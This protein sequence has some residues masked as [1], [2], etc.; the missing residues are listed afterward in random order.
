MSLFRHTLP[1][2][3]QARQQLY[4][5]ITIAALLLL[6]FGGMFLLTRLGPRD[7][8][9]PAA[10]STDRMSGGTR[11]V[12]DATLRQLREDVALLLTAFRQIPGDQTVSAEELRGI[13]EAIELQRRILAGR[14][15]EIA[16]QADVDRLEELLRI[17]DEHMGAFLGAQVRDA[18]AAAE[19][20][21]NIRDHAAAITHLERALHLQREIN[22]RYRR[23]SARNVSRLAILE[24]R[25]QDWRAQPVHD[26]SLQHRARAMAALDRRDFAEARTE[27][28]A[29]LALQRKLYEEHR[30]ARV[31]SLSRLRAF[32]K[33]W[34]D[35]EA[36][37]EAARI[38]DLEQQVLRALDE[39]DAA[40]AID[41][42]EVAIRL[43]Q[44]LAARFPRSEAARP[45]RAEDLLTLRETAASLPGQQRV[46]SLLAE[47]DRLLP[48]AAQEPIALTVAELFR[49]L[50]QLN[51][52]YPRS[53]LLDAGQFA[54]IQALHAIR[55][56][57]AALRDTVY[58]RLVEIPGMPGTR[59]L[60]SEVWQALY[61]G[62]ARANPSSQPGDT[63][64]VESVTW[65][66]AQAFCTMLGWMLARPVSLPNR[67]AYQAALGEVHTW[68]V[69]D[70]SW[71]SQNTDRTLRPVR[72]RP[73]NSNGFIDLL[74][75]VA[76]W[77]DDAVANDTGKAV[78]IGGSVR[79]N[80]FRL[81]AVPEE[82][83]DRGERNRFVG[84]RFMLT[85]RSP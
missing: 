18:E 70:L 10:T 2:S 23:A 14:P 63:L 52:S 33:D 69:V 82:V 45:A 65:D 57:I 44:E 84:F 53:R 16:P 61:A 21:L 80:P 38:S 37:E 34:N 36:A 3:Q 41:R 75:N 73:P 46:N 51:R 30:Q 31:A 49:Q 79:D 66:E 6:L 35:M 47:L 55:E 76:E 68:E 81:A 19:E 60:D 74:G 12:D 7:A 48:A 42:I 29:A 62:I 39:G 4:I 20:A 43:Q 54:R 72:S 32:E 9:D 26:S 28:A 77:L 50:S 1:R 78:A 15:G 71:H 8:T 24:S 13:D 27:M 67:A 5:V 59:M 64:P 83:R 40:S 11:S 58:A 56:D 17:R 85:D 25:L 22:E